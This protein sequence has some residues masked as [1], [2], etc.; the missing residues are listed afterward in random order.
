M[1]KNITFNKLHEGLSY[2]YSNSYFT[3]DASS[4]S[5]FFM[6]ICSICKHRQLMSQQIWMC[7]LIRKQHI[8]GSLGNNVFKGL[9]NALSSSQK[10]I[11]PVNDCTF[12]RHSVLLQVIVTLDNSI[13]KPR[14]YFLRA[15]SSIKPVWPTRGSYNN[16]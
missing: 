13:W 15:F 9:E 5:I 7:N 8:W 12:S 14:K 1:K 11:I 4:T 6:F 3:V 16:I 2:K 10:G